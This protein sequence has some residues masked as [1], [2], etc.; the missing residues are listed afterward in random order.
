M[1]A[2]CVVDHGTVIHQLPTVDA[3]YVVGATHGTGI[4]VEAFVAPEAFERMKTEG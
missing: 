3:A 1:F 4:T 2:F